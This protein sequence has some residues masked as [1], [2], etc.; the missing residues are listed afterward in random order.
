MN[1]GRM[2]WQRISRSVV[3][4]AGTEAAGNECVGHDYRRLAIA[5][6]LLP[7]AGM[8]SA[9]IDTRQTVAMLSVLAV[10]AV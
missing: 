8:N 9:E 7:A 10:F 3:K 4:R 5:K 6:L 1:A 2:R